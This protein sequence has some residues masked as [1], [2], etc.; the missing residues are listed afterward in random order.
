MRVRETG[1]SARLSLDVWSATCRQG[2]GEGEGLV[3]HLPSGMW[4]GRHEEVTR[5]VVGEGGG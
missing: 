3:R 4:L 2:E 5:V 1:G